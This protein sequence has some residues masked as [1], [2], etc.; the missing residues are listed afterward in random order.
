MQP[1]KELSEIT[2]EFLRSRI[3][4]IFPSQIRTCIEELSEEQ[5]WW[6]PNEA[7]NSVGNL[8]LHLS[9]SVRHY[10]CR[11]IGGIEYTRNRPAEFSE[12]GPLPKQELLS[13]FDETIKQSR[14]VLAS[15]DTERFW[16][17]TEEP[18]YYPTIFEQLLGIMAHIATHTG[19]I[20]Y[21]TKAL[22]EGSLDELW[23][24][25]HRGSDILVG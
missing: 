19:Q 24:R 22:K 25:A 8:V 21:I 2:L 14:D 17:A 1:K 12:R 16:D 10:L 9:G 7:S 11:G 18:K 23:I 13:I 15:F 4:Q 3:T 20:L 6:R 5:L